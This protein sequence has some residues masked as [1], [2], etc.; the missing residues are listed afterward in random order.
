[1]KC[2]VCESTVGF[3]AKKIKG[4][5]IC[6]GCLLRL[7]SIILNNSNVISEYNLRYA[8][9]YVQENKKKFCATASYG[10]LHIDEIHGMFC[11]AKSLDK[12]GKPKSGNNVFSVNQLTEVGLTCTSPHVDHNQVIV[13]VEFT[14]SLSDPYISNKAIIKYSAR[15]QTK[16]VDNEHLSWS[17]PN[18]LLMFKTMFNQMLSREMEKVNA[19]LCGK[20]LHEFEIEKARAIFMLEK[21][22]TNDDLKKARRLMM[23]VY[24]PDS[25]KDVTRESQIINDAFN[26]LKIELVKR[27][28]SDENS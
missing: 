10:Q 16:R 1:M 24:H 18:D 4:G 28:A 12:D 13:N 26:L 25:G 7:P 21:D 14:F 2:Y 6:K 15:C 20:T 5:K 3:G 9:N 23:K 27:V 11:V 19:M 17:E 8:I 22:F